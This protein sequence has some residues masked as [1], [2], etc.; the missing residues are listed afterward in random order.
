MGSEM[1]SCPALLV[2]NLSAGYAGQQQA[3]S[4]ASF[5]VQDGER[6]GV[7]GPN[8]AGKS[9]LFKA[10]V[11]LVPHTTGRISIRG[12]DCGVSHQLVGYVPQHN[13]IDWTFPVSVRDVVLMGRI[14]QIGWFRLPRTRDWRKVD[15]LLARVGMAD[16]R[17]RQISEL[18]G[19][20]RQRVFIAR[21]LAQETEVILLDEP[22]SGV[23]V[24]AEQEINRVLDQ[25]H[26]EGVTMMLATHN[27]GAAQ[28]QFDKLLLLK[29]RV[30]AFGEPPQVLIPE[31]LRQAYGKQ[32]AIFHLDGT[33]L[34]VAD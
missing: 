28:T 23:D 12:E 19:G 27:L 17:F 22:F 32:V 1:T 33:A 10:I 14:R 3:L 6:I 7:L 4:N 8:G 30:V 34:V 20:Q 31:Y 24:A 25:L 11:G 26:R 5:E 18:S 9:T 21:A 29:N 2:E 16:F 15:D 13:E